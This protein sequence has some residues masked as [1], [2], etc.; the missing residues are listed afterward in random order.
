MDM[1]NKALGFFITD[2]RSETRTDLPFPDPALLVMRLDEKL[3]TVVNMA[4]APFVRPGAETLADGQPFAIA[5]DHPVR[6]TWK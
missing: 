6:G 3:Q 4:Y 2:P 1:T 5:N